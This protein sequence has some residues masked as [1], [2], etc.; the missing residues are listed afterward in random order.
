MLPLEVVVR[1]SLMLLV[2]SHI[3]KN[4][5][6]IESKCGVYNRRPSRWALS[7]GNNSVLWIPEINR[8]SRCGKIYDFR[9]VQ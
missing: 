1:E 8:L 4:D 7:N 2:N 9:T 6:D 5:C 3:L